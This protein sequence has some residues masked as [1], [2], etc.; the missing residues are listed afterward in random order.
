ML[1]MTSQTDL[2]AAAREH[3]PAD[4]ADTWLSLLR[5]GIRLINAD[6]GD[7]PAVGYLGGEPQLP[8]D[9]AWPVWEGHGPLSFIA[10][11]DCAALPRVVTELGLPIDGR[12]L[13]FY[14]DG[15][16][17][18]GEA[19][20]FAS[21]P[22]SQAGARVLYVPAGRASAQRSTPEGIEPYKRL[23]LASRAVSTP[24]SYDHPV[25]HDAFGAG[26]T[27]VA[28]PEHPLRGREFCSAISCGEGPLHQLGGYAYP[29]QGDV[30]Y[31]V[32]QAALGGNVGWR[33]PTL[34]SEAGQWLLLAQFDSDDNANMMWGDVGMLYWLIRPDDLAARRFDRA[35]FTWQ[36]C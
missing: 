31:E 2:A 29:V 19:M 32:A 12:L 24:P 8:D 20:V 16:Y 28:E 34:A 10:S 21:D 1:G 11:V 5:P 23:R 13:F 9:V 30:E 15:Q 4:V 35:M 17:D 25:L 36:C 14:F 6:D 18:D 33:D 26:F 7:G 22:K 3:L 27:Q